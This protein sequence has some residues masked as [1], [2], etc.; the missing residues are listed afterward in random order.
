MLNIII[1]YLNDNPGF[2]ILIGGVFSIITIFGLPYLLVNFWKRFLRDEKATENIDLEIG[3]NFFAIFRNKDYFSIEIKN[4]LKAELICEKV[5]LY[6][7]HGI[8]RKVFKKS[9]SLEIPQR[10]NSRGFGVYYKFRKD[11]LE[12]NELYIFKMKFRNKYRKKFIYK[13][14]FK[15]EKGREGQGL[16]FLKFTGVQS[17]K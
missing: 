16:D 12:N 11:R 1:E 10:I 17:I 7:K 4:K 14:E 2:G 9:K 8:F 3:D 15:F 5:Y 6:P 13:S